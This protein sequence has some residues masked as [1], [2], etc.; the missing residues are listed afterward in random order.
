MSAPRKDFTGEEIRLIKAAQPKVEKNLG[1]KFNKFIPEEIATQVVSGTMYFVKLHV[2]PEKL[3]PCI[4][5]RIYQPLGKPDEGENE[6]SKCEF[7][8]I[9]TGKNEDDKLNYFESN[10][11]SIS[12]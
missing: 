10:T 9:L 12:L 6:F 4:H 3:G 7:D 5:M 1:I 2:C 11:E 8:G